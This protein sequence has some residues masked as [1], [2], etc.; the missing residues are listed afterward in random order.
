[1]GTS[2]DPQQTAE[3]DRHAR[4]YD[5]MHRAS[6]QA[7]GEDPQYFAVYKQRCLERLLGKDLGRPILDFG[8]GIGNLTSLLVESFAEVDGFDPS[9]ESVKVAADRAPR[10]RFYHSME[11][12]PR[13]KYGAVVVANVLHH[14]PPAERPELLGKLHELLAPGG[15]VVV[16]EH[17]PLNPV[18]RRA[19]AACPFDDNAELLWPWEVKGLL[20]GAGLVEVDLDYI[21][22]FPRLLAAMRG[23]EPKMGWLPIGAQVCSWGTKR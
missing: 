8:C 7:S 17:N 10:A 15:R 21:V 11:S 22:F 13:D 20:R 9:A 3:F 2:F 12:I 4:G 1:M 23:L 18:T 6:I 5:D 14:V 16:F 19:V